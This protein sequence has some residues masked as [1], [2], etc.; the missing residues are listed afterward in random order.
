MKTT[1]S[2]L[3]VCH[4]IIRSSL[5]FLCLVSEN[6]IYIM[7]SHQLVKPAVHVEECYLKIY[8]VQEREVSHLDQKATFLL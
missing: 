5:R 6:N 3:V 7:M 2:C 8:L 1:T 4:G